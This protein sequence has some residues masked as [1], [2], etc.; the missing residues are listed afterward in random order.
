M[1]G[2]NFFRACCNQMGIPCDTR[3]KL[4]A[5]NSKNSGGYVYH[6]PPE[7]RTQGAALRRS[8]YI[9]DRDIYLAW[10]LSVS[11][12]ENKTVFRV[13]ADELENMELGRVKF[14]RKTLKRCE[15]E[16]ETVYAFDRAAVKQFLTIAS[17]EMQKEA[18]L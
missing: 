16:K 18:A 1:N 14:I 8:N 11:G 17:D 3:F 7:L 10:D 4:G 15:S 2:K 9:S 5:Q 13:R 6:C 12:T